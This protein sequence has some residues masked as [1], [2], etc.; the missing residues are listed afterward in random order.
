MSRSVRRLLLVLCA[1]AVHCSDAVADDASGTARPTAKRILSRF[2]KGNPGWKVRMRSLTQLAKIGPAVVPALADALKTGSPSTREFAAQA[3]GMF[4]EASARPALEQ[5]LKDPKA[6]VRIY[7]IRALRSFG[8]L[9]PAKRYEKMTSDPDRNVR[10]T[11]RSALERKDK[12]NADALRRA[13]AEYD[14]TK[15][16]T[17]RIGKPAP[18]FAL[19]TFGGKRVKLSDFRGKQ[20][21][22]LRFIKL[23]Y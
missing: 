20:T 4:A 21:V 1:L 10:A 17:A 3:L 9:T 16:N 13:W 2:D 15:M 23:D 19:T 11:I 18:D 22:V 5:A 8:P 6:T 7:A 12:S 14:L